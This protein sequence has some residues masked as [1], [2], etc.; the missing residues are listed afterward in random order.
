MWVKIN[1]YNYKIIKTI[2][3]YIYRNISNKNKSTIC[4]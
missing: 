2:F 3:V 1:R 4:S